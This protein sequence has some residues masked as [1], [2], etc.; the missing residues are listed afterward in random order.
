MLTTIIDGI[1]F[2]HNDNHNIFVCHIDN[3]SNTLKDELRNRFRTICHGNT[4]METFNYIETLNSFFYRYNKKTEDQKMGIIG[5]LLCH[6]LL[7]KH[8]SSLESSSI[9]FNKESAG[10]KQGFDLI[11]FDKIKN[12]H[13]YGEV[14]SG[15]CNT[16]QSANTKNKDLLSLAKSDLENKLSS[17]R[18]TLWDAAI[19]DTRATLT[20]KIRDKVAKLLKD[21]YPLNNT[22]KLISRV[23]LMSV[24]FHTLSDEIL[25]AELND[26]YI[27]FSQTNSFSSI[28]LFSTQKT[29]F[30]KIEQFLKN[31]LSALHE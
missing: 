11:Y 19:L 6:L 27:N 18:I 17:G 29:T 23:V 25:L 30:E 3:F 5:E 9:L 26:L 1:R 8:I 31:E 16:I 13:W 24:L 15:H 12:E 20:E 7:E 10:I 2:T 14:K 21:D 22:N 28:L 4:N